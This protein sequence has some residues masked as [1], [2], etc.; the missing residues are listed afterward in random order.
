MSA[1]VKYGTEL[2]FVRPLAAPSAAGRVAVFSK[3]DEERERLAHR[4]A[5]LEEDLRQREGAAEMLREEAERQFRQGQENG[6]AEALAEIQNHQSE[7]LRLLEDSITHA[8]AGV[9]ETLASCERL[10]AALARDCLDKMLSDTV[11]RAGLVEQIIAAQIG[12]IDKTMILAVEVSE[13]DFPVDEI[14][15]M[16]ARLGLPNYSVQT[17]TDLPPGG[18]EMA[19]RL[20][21]VNIGLHQQWGVLRGALDGMAMPEGSA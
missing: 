8:R 20:G 16:T 10:A 11:D 4:I 7:H 15:A 3:Q 13:Q 5:V 12:K 18:C 9:S 1:I 14:A 21:R 2:A 19:L 6:R 17:R